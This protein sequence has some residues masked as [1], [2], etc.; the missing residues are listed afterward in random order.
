MIIVQEF[1]G[2]DV[3][4]GSGKEETLEMLSSAVWVL[5]DVND[6][7]VRTQKQGH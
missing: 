5:S 6:S 3:C 4:A 1:L 7:N 2:I